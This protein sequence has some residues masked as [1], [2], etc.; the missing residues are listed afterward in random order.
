[1]QDHFD[2]V[3]IGGGF[4]GCYIA[5]ELKRQKKGSVIIVEREPELLK[6]ASFNNQARVHNGYHY[7]RSF[8]TGLS[9]RV[10]F[11]RFVRDFKDCINNTFEQYYAVGKIQSKVTLSQFQIFCKRIGAPLYPAPADVKSI[12]N[13]KLIEDVFLVKEYAFDA[14]KL[15][16]MISDWIKGL[17]I[18]VL[19]NTEAQAISSAAG[20]KSSLKVSL[21]DKVTNQEF[22]IYG[23]HVFN[24]TY[25]NI[26]TILANS[27]IPKIHLKQ[28]LTEIALVEMPDY[29]NNKGITVMCGPFFSFMPFPPNLLHSFSHVRYTPHHYWYDLDMN[30]NN[31]TYFDSMPKKSCFSRM[32]QDAKRYIPLLA[33][34]S[35]IDSLWEI[36]TILPQSE[37]DDSRP[38]LFKKDAGLR[39]LTCIMGGKIDNVYDLKEELESII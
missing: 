32:I 17:E 25:S 12:F 23:S 8:L 20:S 1:M 27:G 9:S 3:V 33:E 18:P 39:N 15:G 37:V 11:Q 38:I 10:N 5:I 6:R 35:Y 19:F 30:I 14:I 4:F 22:D 24:C 13:K 2:V 21:R 28:E 36:K 7:P 29:F 26:N 31:Q 34:C 16:H